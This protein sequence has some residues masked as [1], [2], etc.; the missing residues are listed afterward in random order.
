APA[1]DA[2]GGITGPELRLACVKPGEQISIFGDALREIAERSAHLYESEGRYWYGPRA[3]LNKLAENRQLDVDND[4][5]DAEIIRLLKLDE[6]TKGNWGRVHTA[7]DRASEV[8]D[9]PTSGLVILSP[10]RPYQA[11]GGSLAEVE[12]LDGLDRRAGGQRKYRNALIFLAAD[13]RG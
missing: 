9:R 4:T 10:G 12:A 2:R 11:G 6:R 13:E 5:A 8:E 1:G 3:T 7:P